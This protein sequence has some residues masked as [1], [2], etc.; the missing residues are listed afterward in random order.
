[1]SHISAHAYEE[2]HES[3]ESLRDDGEA[4][5]YCN[6]CG[7]RFEPA[8]LTSQKDDWCVCARCADAIAEMCIGRIA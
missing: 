2:F 4:S 8:E 6:A 7:Q 3:R 1:M 5:L